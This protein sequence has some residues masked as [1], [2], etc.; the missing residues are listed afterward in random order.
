M[1]CS[2]EVVSKLWIIPTR[3]APF[4]DQLKS[5]LLRLSK[6]SDERRNCLFSDTVAGAKYSANRYSL[7]ETAR[8]DGLDPYEYLRR[9]FTDLPNAKTVA[10]IEA[11][12]PAAI[13]PVS[14]NSQHS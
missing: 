10:D 9:A 5:Q 14:V 4:S 1:L 3:S 2:R 8:A 7:I 6:R 11:L 12:L 13:D